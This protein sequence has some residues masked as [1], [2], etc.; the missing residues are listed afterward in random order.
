MK[1]F[2]CVSIL[3]GFAV[4]GFAQEVPRYSFAV[5]GGYTVPAGSASSYL[6]GG[7]NIGGGAGVNFTPYLG[8]MLDF[9]FD[10][11]GISSNVLSSLGDTA[12]DVKTYSLTLDP[13]IHLL[14]KAPLDVYITGGGGLYHWKQDFTQP[15]APLTMGFNSFFGIYPTGMTPLGYGINKPGVDIGAGV[16]LKHKWGGEFFAEAKYNYIY[17]GSYHAAY[18]PMTFGFR[19]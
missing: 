8:A 4:A 7:Y 9:S 14:P 18:I 2:V 13:I 19:R 10:S 15:A 17:I 12:G 11:M 6:D 5:S 16:G 1:T 3:A